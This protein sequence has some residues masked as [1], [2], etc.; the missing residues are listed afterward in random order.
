MTEFVD[1]TRSQ[2]EAFKNLDRDQPINMLN[3]V[4]LRDQADYPDDHALSG[5]GLT[6]QQA[7]TRY[8]RESAPVLNKVGGS[9]L[10]RGSFQMTLIG[11]SEEIWDQVFIAAYPSAHAFLQ[12]IT[13]PEYRSAVVHR[14]AG[15]ASSRLIR[16]GPSDAG[17]AFG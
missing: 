3:L 5:R 15:V 13:D 9:I 10:W 16:C 11:P 2:F 1:P 6:G 8:G 4:C 17:G 7:Y 12:M 14:Q